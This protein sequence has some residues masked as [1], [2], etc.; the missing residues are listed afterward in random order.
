M[1]VSSIPKVG[2]FERSLK[3]ILKYWNLEILTGGSRRATD[4]TVF[5]KK[6]NGMSLCLL[7]T[8]YAC[9]SYTTYCRRTSRPFI[10][11]VDAQSWYCVVLR[12]LF[13]FILI[14]MWAPGTWCLVLSTWVDNIQ[15]Q[16]KG[17][18]T[19]YEK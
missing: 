13:Y 3:R 12:V 10:L 17:P 1:Q 7:Y 6:N 9:I 16:W 4:R 8:L 14:I 19:M 2:I 15:I 11:L 5:E 18:S